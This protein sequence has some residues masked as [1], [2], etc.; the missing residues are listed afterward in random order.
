VKIVRINIISNEHEIKFVNE[1]INQLK[2]KIALIN[3]ERTLERQ[4]SK[5]VGREEVKKTRNPRNGKNG[6]AN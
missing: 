3:T 4:K 1:S 6:L 5:C 2:L